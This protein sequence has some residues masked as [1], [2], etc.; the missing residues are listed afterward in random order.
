MCTCVLLFK[1]VAGYPVVMAANREEQY[2][3]PS[4]PPSWSAGKTGIFAGRDG[5]QGGTWQG[6]NETGLL[7]ALTNRISG[8]TDPDLRSRGRLCADA[9]G[10]PSSGTAI[11]WTLGHLQ[12]Q[13]YN[14]F[15]MIFVDAEQALVLHYAGHPDVRDL[16]PGLHVLT[17][18]DMDDQ[19]HPRVVRCRVLLQGELSKD[20]DGTQATLSGF[21]ADHAEDGASGQE[22]CRHGDGGG[23]VSSSLVAIGSEG[24]QGVRFHFA[25]GPPCTHVYEDLSPQ[26]AAGPDH[27]SPS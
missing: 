4:S 12:G 21:M 10:Q 8:P 11:D 24:L 2:E 3:R 25:P 26:L 16:R 19:S 22:L 18:T 14:P 7:V 23:T 9:L 15:N 17:D 1:L 27:G 6:V 13:N 5:V 20:W